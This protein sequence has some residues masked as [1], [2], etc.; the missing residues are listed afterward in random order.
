[1]VYLDPIKLKIKVRKPS[2][3]SKPNR[4]VQKE[5][6]VYDIGLN[7]PAEIEIGLEGNIN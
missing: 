5:K 7:R 4:I 2:S 3:R 6:T 1:M